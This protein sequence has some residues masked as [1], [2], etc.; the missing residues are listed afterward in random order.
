MSKK[1]FISGS[2]R[3]I[4]RGL[5][6][7]FAKMGWDVA[8][9]YNSSEVKALETKR[10]IDNLGVNC[11]AVKAD[12]CNYKEFD[13]A[14]TQAVDYMGVPD[15]F[16]NNSGIFPAKQSLENSS[17]EIW[18]NTLNTNLRSE[19]YGAKLFAT[20]ASKGAKIINVGSLGGLEIWKSRIPYNV[21]KA[22]VIQLTKALALELLLIYQ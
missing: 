3:R 6:I 12:V 21:S 13:R 9:H 1:I 11:I 2:G 20:I 4:G 15:V 17:I 8:I 18:D 16:I 10:T 7:N 14:F 19:F 5:A 22:G